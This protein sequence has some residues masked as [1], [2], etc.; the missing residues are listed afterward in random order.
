[1]NFSP[2]TNEFSPKVVVLPP[3]GDTALPSEKGAV[4]TVEPQKRLRGRPQK[5]ESEYPV[6]PRRPTESEKHKQAFRDYIAMGDD[7]SL[8]KV[9]LAYGASINTVRSWSQNFDWEARLRLYLS[10]SVTKRGMDELKEIWLEKIFS[11]REPDPEKPGKKK[12]GPLASVENIRKLTDTGVEY[13]RQEI[14]EEERL[15]GSGSGGSGK[16]PRGVMVNVIFK[17]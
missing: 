7:R 14:E 16:G 15:N 8:E 5:A 11:L 12:N 2:E 9:A 6:E 13:R 10:Q 4:I 1:M 17:G 3:E